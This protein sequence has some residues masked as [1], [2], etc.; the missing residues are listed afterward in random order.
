MSSD[1]GDVLISYRVWFSPLCTPLYPP[2]VELVVVVW[3]CLVSR[4]DAVGFSRL[5][6]TSISVRQ[7]VKQI[8][9]GIIEGKPHQT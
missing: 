5:C 9:L 1:I 3:F 2:T 6:N 4:I 7:F 8:V